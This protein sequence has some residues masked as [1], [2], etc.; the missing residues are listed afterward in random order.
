MLIITHGKGGA[1]IVYNNKEKRYLLKQVAIEVDPSGA[2]DAFLS[3]A[4]KK[5]IEN[6]FNISEVM[7]DELF[8]EA[9]NLSAETVQKLGARSVLI[10]LYNKNIETGKCICGLKLN[11]KKNKR[12]IK[13]TFVNL[14]NLKSRVNNALKTEAYQKLSI[15]IEKLEGSVAFIGTGGSK[16][17]A[18][19]SSKVVNTIKGITTIPLTPRELI[20]RNNKDIKRLFA[21]SYSGV[22]NDILYALK[23]N[24]KIEQYIVTKGD[25]NKILSKYDKAKII[26]YCKKNNNSVKERG[27]LSFEGVLSPCSLFAKLY[28]EN[29]NEK[30]N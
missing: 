30:D 14:I 9:S 23:Q 13:K 24:S 1:T 2:G 20:Y 19:F 28:Y 15:E 27:F 5:C 18:I 29:L 11:S 16:I 8:D 26:S 10:D 25:E 21:F 17:P 12:N 22:S 6:D 3:V 4:I 7:L